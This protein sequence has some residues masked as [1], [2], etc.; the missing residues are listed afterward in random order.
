[1]PSQTSF[2]LTSQPYLFGVARKCLTAESLG[3]PGELLLQ[4]FGG[5]LRQTQPDR[6]VGRQE[7]TGNNCG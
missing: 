6:L 1:M 2:R 5:D 7:Q 4:D 3:Q